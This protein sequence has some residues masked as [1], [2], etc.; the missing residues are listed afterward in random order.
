MWCLYS[1]GRESAEPVRIARTS[2]MGHAKKHWARQSKKTVLQK[3]IFR[4]HVRKN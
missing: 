3:D 1:G 4:D 2:L